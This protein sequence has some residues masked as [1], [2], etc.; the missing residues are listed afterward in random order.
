MK[1][2][3]L[4]LI[5]S[6]LASCGGVKKTTNKVTTED[7]A[8]ARLIENHYTNT[9]DFNTLVARTRVRYQDNKSRQTV[10]V[11]IRIEKDKKIWMSASILGITGA[12]ALITPEKISFYE[13]INRRYFEG[14]FSFLSQ[15]FGVQMDF[16]QLQRLLIGQTVYNLREGDYQVDQVEG[17]YK[18]TPKKQLDILN[19]FFF[20]EP[21]DFL[22]KKQ[23]VTQPQDNLSLDVN[24]TSHQLVKGKAFPKSI[25]IEVLENT[26]KTNIDIEYRS[27]EADVPVRFPF[28]IPSGYK[29]I[30]LDEL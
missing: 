16:E 28:S 20:M 4:L 1:R 6:V 17:L 8:T 18:I 27:V 7:I 24:Y 23:Q 30:T 3:A 11:S 26:D 13:K 14:D 15:Y 5:I 10:T 12:K 29:K 19:L 25:A 21:Q 9:F 22:I 2:L